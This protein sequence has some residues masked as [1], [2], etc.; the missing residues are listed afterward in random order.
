MENTLSGKESSDV[1]NLKIGSRIN[2][3]SMMLLLLSHKQFG[4][5]YWTFSATFF[6]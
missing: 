3:H 4:H 5:A 6:L 2:E 1:N